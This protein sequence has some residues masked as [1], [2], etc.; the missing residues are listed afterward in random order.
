MIKNSFFLSSMFVYINTLGYILHVIISRILGP[1]KYGEFMVIYSF[2]LAIGFLST[3]YPNLTIKMVI[4]DGNIRYDIFRFIRLTS[5]GIGFLLWVF[6][7][8]NSEFLANFLRIEKEY[9]LIIP[10]IWFLIF[11]NSVEKGFLQAKERF[12]MYSLINSFELTIRFFLVLF[13]LY[14]GYEIWGIM[15]ATLSALLI[16]FIL[17]LLI[18]KNLFGNIKPISFKK[19]SITVLTTIPTGL[20]IYADDIFIRRIFDSKTAG[21]YASASIVGKAFTWF[22]ITIFSVYFIKIVKDST[23]YKN[24][25]FRYFVFIL[26]V[27]LLT[28]ILILTFGKEIFTFLFGYKFINAFDYLKVY[29]PSNIPLILSVAIITANISIEKLTKYVYLHLFCYYAGF[30]VFDFITPYHYLLYIF[31]LNSIFLSIYCF[32]IFKNFS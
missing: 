14:L 19:F 16:S 32:K 8:I 3:V 2:M 27:S 30:L 20:F 4:E 5:V 15:F 13:F 21:L 9:L 22:C 26:S 12:G 11:L 28:E 25:V 23:A 24:L 6:I 17:L 18:N 31:L 29:I 10:F 1:E 7:L